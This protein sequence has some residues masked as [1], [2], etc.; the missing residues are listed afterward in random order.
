MKKRTVYILVAAVIILVVVILFLVL[1]SQNRNSASAFT[2]DP[3]QRGQLTAIIGG[4]GTVRANQTTQLSWQTS[5]RIG[6]ID[7]SID[8]LVT[9]GTVLAQ[10]SDSSLNQSIILARADLVE[11]ERSLDN[12]ITSDTASAQAF[13]TLVAAQQELDDA[14]EKRESKQYGRADPE[15]LDIAEAQLVIAEDQVSKAEQTFDLVNNR[16]EN[17]P[18][19]ASAFASLAETKQERDRKLANLNWLLGRPDELEVSEVNARVQ[20]AESKLAD[21]TR[22]WERLKD[23]PDPDDINSAE[24]RVAALRST[25]SLAELTAPFDATVTQINSKVGDEISPGTV[26]FRLDDLSKLL[27]DVL[28]PEVDINQVK[29]DQAVRLTFDAILNQEYEGTVSEVARVGTETGGV[30]NFMVTIEITNPDDRVLPGMTAAVNIIVNQLDDVFL[31]P[32]R[33]VRLLQGE[34][35]VYVLRDNQPVSVPITIGATADLFS[36]LVSGDLQEG[37]LI[38]LNPPSQE[39]RGGPFGGPP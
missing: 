35:V 26:T 6:K 23:G 28:I 20:V 24:A 9:T 16:L 11:A 36:E 21:A 7:V 10:L 5:G 37:A 39:F 33:A 32:N 19:R 27:V 18:I 38:I 2:T 13:Q 14:K 12:L 25:L 29:V 31:I 30:V 8:D 22:E 34:R 4:T 1:G 15:T 3:L 17:D